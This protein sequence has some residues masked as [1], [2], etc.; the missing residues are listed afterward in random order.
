M[1]APE[2]VVFDWDGTLVD[3]EQHIVASIRYAA[4]KLALPD[5]EHD[6]VKQIIGL[7]MQEALLTLYQD[8]SSE[9]VKSMRKHY[10]EHFFK[11]QTGAANLFSGVHE[12]LTELRRKGLRL[13]VATGKSRNGLDKALKSTGLG[14]YFDIERCADES[15]SKPDPLM[16]RQI[17]D[18][19]QS[20][21]GAMIMVGDTSYD[22][23][24]AAEV[25]MP[26]LA[27]SY[28]VHV[29]SRLRE[30]QPLAVIDHISEVL[31]FV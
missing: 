30:H 4:S 27:V 12:T 22:M 3:S 2:I 24:M 10:S 31:N 13:A 20:D 15:R 14:G 5:L 25:E 9:Q 7:G 26:A 1:T 6:C 23:Q 18:H 16:L 29:E 19:Y 21:F 8:L 28:G 17:A 11:T